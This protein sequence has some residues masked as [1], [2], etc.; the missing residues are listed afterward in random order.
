MGRWVLW[1]ASGCGAGRSGQGRPG[2]V[3]TARNNQPNIRRWHVKTDCQTDPK[4]KIKQ[5]FSFFFI[6]SFCFVKFQQGTC[7]ETV[8]PLNN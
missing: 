5:V 6:G 7:F 2:A 1:T 4:L 3:N 8:C